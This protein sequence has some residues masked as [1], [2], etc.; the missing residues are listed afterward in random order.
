MLHLSRVGKNIDNNW[1]LKAPVS[2]NHLYHS[3]YTCTKWWYFWFRASQQTT[4]CNVNHNPKYSA[5]VSCRAILGRRNVIIKLLGLMETGHFICFI[6]NAQYP[7]VSYRCL[8]LTSQHRKSEKYSLANPSSHLVF[9]TWKARS[10]LS[11]CTISLLQVGEQ[12]AFSV[13]LVFTVFPQDLKAAACS[14]PLR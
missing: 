14:N 7:T 13:K 11:P 10:T 3:Q 2:P 1:R 8:L 5:F 9:T 6:Q 4:H 12:P